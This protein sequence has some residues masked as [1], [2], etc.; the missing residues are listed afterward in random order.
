MVRQYGQIHLSGVLDCDG[1][2]ISAIHEGVFLHM[3]DKEKVSA[4]VKEMTANPDWNEVLMRAPGAANLRIALAFYASKN[5]DSMSSQ[6]KDEYREFRENLEAQLTAGELKYLSEEFGRM[7][8]DA[9]KQH[10]NDLFMKKPPEEQQKGQQEYA[11]LGSGGGGAPSG[12]DQGGDGEDSDPEQ[13]QQQT[14]HQ[15]D[16]NQ[17]QEE[18]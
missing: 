12:G 15:D 1:V 10:Y 6:E 4:A 3:I 7:G 8:V 2:V 18:K 13:P 11:S 9:A 16:G 14:E 5:L 17:Q